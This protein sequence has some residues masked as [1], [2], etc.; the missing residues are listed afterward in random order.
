MSSGAIPPI[1]SDDFSSGNFSNWTGNTNLT[2][3]N[4]TGSPA[5]PS[6]RAQASGQAASA[7]RTLPSTAMT[8]CA[9]VRIN[10]TSA[11]GA[12]DLFRLRTAANGAVIKVVVATGNLQIR[13]DFGSTT[14]NSGVALGTGF[15]DV[16][17]CGTVGTN[18][19]WDLYRDGVKIVDAWGADT[20]TSPVGRIQIGDTVAKTFTV[21]FDHVVVDQVPG[22]N[23]APDTSPPT[24]PGTPSGSSPSTGNIQIGWAAS[25]DDTPPITYRIYR[26]GNPT[27]I[28][29]TTATTYLD[30]GLTPG[31]SHTYTVDAVDALAHPSAMSPASA[32]ILVSSG[33]IPP[34]FSDDFSSGNFSNWTG[35]TNLTIDN[36]TG[37][38]AAPSA[39]AQASGQAA[40]AYR[41][42]PSTAMTVCASVRINVTSATGAIDLFRLRTAANGAVIKVV[43]L[44]TGNLQIRSDFGS[45]TI[46][47]GVALGT[48]FHDVELCGTVGTTSS[49]DLYRDGVKIVDAWGADTGT[50]PVGRIQIGDTVAKTFTVNFDHVVVDQV[51]GWTPLRRSPSIRP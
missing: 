26:D 35:N 17:L 40:W 38:P 12:I 5:A 18:S 39:R 14:I 41:T 16:E 2:I 51:V 44:A 4:A 42:L 29:Q 6:A 27:P 10:V 49:W 23:Q 1:F 37:S 7:Y 24:V 15:H 46:N 45:T 31:S 19:S 22:E 32:S 9:S 3:D 34:I 8:V 25:T 21:N 47:S 48:G 20:G 43:R 13:S 11:T 28:G 30:S 36:A 33:A 50:S